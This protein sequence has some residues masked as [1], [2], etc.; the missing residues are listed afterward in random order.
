[1]GDSRARVIHIASASSRIQRTEYD[2]SESR[3]VG[4]SRLPGY[5]VVR[6]SILLFWSQGVGAS[7]LHGVE[8]RLEQF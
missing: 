4:S 8:P 6:S 2:P 5:M 3:A 7:Q 1:M